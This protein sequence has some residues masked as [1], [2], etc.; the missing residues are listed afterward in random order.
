MEL[1]SC[2]SQI[3]HQDDTLTNIIIKPTCIPAC[4]NYELDEPDEVD[5][6]DEE[7]NSINECIYFLNDKYSG[8]R[9]WFANFSIMISKLPNLAK[10]TFD[11]LNIHARELERFWGEI[12][13]SASL[14]L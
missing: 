12:S 4:S 5:S 10:L 14:Q 7:D 9:E 8:S 13:A 2:I 1:G 3:I 6:I 11:Q